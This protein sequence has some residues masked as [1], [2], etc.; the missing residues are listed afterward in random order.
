[1]D[2]ERD[3]SP[4][5]TKR[6][7]LTR[8]EFIEAIRTNDRRLLRVEA[9][10]YFRAWGMDDIPVTEVPQQVITFLQSSEVQDVPCTP[11]LLRKVTLAAVNIRTG[12]TRYTLNREVC[13]AG[14]R[15]LLWRE[16]PIVSLGCG[17]VGRAK[18]RRRVEAPPA[19]PRERVTQTTITTQRVARQCAPLPEFY[20]GMIVIPTLEDRGAWLDCNPQADCADEV[21]LRFIRGDTHQ[22]QMIKR[23]WSRDSSHRRRSFAHAERPSSDAQIREITGQGIRGGH[24]ALK[25][26]TFIPVDRLGPT[27]ICNGAGDLYVVPRENGQRVAVGLPNS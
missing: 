25:G 17:N 21:C 18:E 19:Q 23:Y 26:A 2:D 16:V 3:W 20:Y 8:A 1:V 7:N 6:Q 27:V 14:E 15:L 22:A 24:A 5:Y 12:A 9:S 10:E 4:W 13:Y 11:A